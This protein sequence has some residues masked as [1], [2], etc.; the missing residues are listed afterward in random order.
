MGCSISVVTPSY[1]QG[2]FIE[3]TIASVLSQGVPDMEYLVFDGGSTDD[4][5]SILQSYEPRI[6]WVSRKDGGRRMPSIKAFRL[7]AAR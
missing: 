2:R 6:R 4:T 7:P 1:N 3:R 5:V